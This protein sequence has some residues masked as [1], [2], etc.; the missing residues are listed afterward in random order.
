MIR[1]LI[2]MIA[3]IPAAAVADEVLAARVDAILQRNCVVC[4]REGGSAPFSLETPTLQTQHAPQI[5]A[6]IAAG[7]MPPW[8]AVNSAGKFLNDFSLTPLERDQLL[9]WCETSRPAQSPIQAASIPP[10][11]GLTS[12]W[13]LGEPKAM[14]QA[15]AEA[16]AP[17][18]SGFWTATIELNNRTFLRARAIEVRTS[19]GAPMQQA[20]ILLDQAATLSAP[21]AIPAAPSKFNTWV[22]KSTQLLPWSRR[23]GESRPLKERTARLLITRD[24]EP[25]GLF[26]ADSPAMELPQ[27]V[28]WV[29]PP[30]SKLHVAW[31]NGPLTRPS[32]DGQSLDIGIHL[33]SRDGESLRTPRVVVLRGKSHDEIGGRVKRDE[34]VAPVPLTVESI[35]AHGTFRMR[36]AHVDV[37]QN[38]GRIESLLWIDRFD[39]RWETTYRFAKPERVPRGARLEFS[40]LESAHG[41]PPLPTPFAS[42]NPFEDALEHSFACVMLIPIEPGD[43]A[44]LDRVLWSRR[45]N[46][47]PEKASFE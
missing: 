39:P 18:A 2:A 30:G 28:A 26:S 40:A 12:R 33:V 5:A 19:R 47:N 34:F 37:V 3:S 17:N 46:P 36:D 14:E 32:L 13:R 20:W 38:D 43:Q 45:V 31:R 42:D 16:A 22:E 23:P 4:H 7:K 44:A 41:R 1:L 15:K 10:P 6:A 29:F 27:G 21:E 8:K 24:L 9:L 25:I 35:A 11:Q